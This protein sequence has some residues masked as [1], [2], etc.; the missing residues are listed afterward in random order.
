VAKIFQGA[1]FEEARDAVREV[2]GKVRVMRPK[3]TRDES[4]ELFFVGL[5]FQPASS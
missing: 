2:F 3:A 4:Y 5:N 1:E